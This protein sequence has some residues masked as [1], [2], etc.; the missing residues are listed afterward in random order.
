MITLTCYGQM[1]KRHDSD[2]E[3]DDK[4]EERSMIPETDCR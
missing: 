2:K 3:E 4:E 1:I